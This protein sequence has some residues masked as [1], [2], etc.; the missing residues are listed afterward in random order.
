M[1]VFVI[2]GSHAPPALEPANAPFRGVARLVPFPRAELGVRAPGPGRNDGL[3]ALPRQS[4][5]QGADA[6]G[7]I[8]EQAG[9][10]RVRSRRPPRP[11]PGCGC[12]GAGRPSRAGI[13]S[14]PVDQDAD[15][16]A[17]AAP[18]TFKDGIRL[19]FGV[20]PPYM[21]G[22]ARPCCPAARRQIRINLLVGHQA[23]R[24]APVAPVGIAARVP[25]PVLDRPSAPRGRR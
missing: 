13:E 20:R 11:A 10:R 21:R 2:A 24:D 8:R 22:R 12:R 14:G 1:R 3:Q 19:I 9:P 15:L 6:I 18:A 23:R 16:G 4:G 7:L 17:E 5:A 25:L